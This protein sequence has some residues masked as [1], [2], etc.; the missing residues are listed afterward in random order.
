MRWV[1]VVPVKPA[2]DGKT[3]LAGVLSASARERLVRA[4][5]LDTVAAAVATPEVLRVVVVTADV[6]LR[7]LLAG[8]VDLVDEPGGGL[9]GAVRAGVDRAEGRREGVAVLL[10]DLPA[11]RP[12]DL[13]DALGM[14]SAH[15][16]AFV[17]D[18]DG[19][20]TTLLAALPG[21]ALDPAFGPGSA[22][23]HELAGHV[24]LAVVGTSTVRRDVDVPDDLVEVARLGVG[25]ATRA[26]I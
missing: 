3:R 25:P 10:G 5:A 6:P 11:L 24:R 23:A 21:V 15:E 20:G 18:A 8:T 2:A 22:A 17:A 9:N 16:R 1:V 7:T 4:M 13:A 26:V 12:D 14:A 19:T